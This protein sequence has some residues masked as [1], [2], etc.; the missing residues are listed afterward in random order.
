M[1]P[2]LLHMKRI[3]ITFLSAALL[4]ACGEESKEK[5][6][7]TDKGEPQDI[8][9]Q[10]TLQEESS[11]E[12][13]VRYSQMGEIAM[14]CENDTVVT[15]N[16]ISF[17]EVTPHAD[18]LNERIEAYVIGD[19]DFGEVDASSI[20][21]AVDQFAAD[22]E[23]EAKEF[24]TPCWDFTANADVVAAW[25]NKLTVEYSSYIYS[26]GA[27]GSFWNTFVNLNLNNGQEF[28]LTDVVTDTTALK[29][30][31]EDKFRDQYMDGYDTY[32][33]AGFWIQEGQ[34]PFASTFGLME[35]GIVFVYQ[36]YEIAPYAGG[37][38][39][40]EVKYSE[41]ESFLTDEFKD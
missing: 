1:W 20:K 41:I 34:F 10:D 6:T 30:V 17:D 22:A 39:D 2:F 19:L 4:T 7:S 8:V 9:E 36:L 26:G 29:K 3:T 11:E 15:V 16:Y 14:G 27:H 40:V 31:V 5:E 12:L 25:D 28:D 33:S 23:A 18:M 32:Q 13:E 38:Q 21:E 37:M 24:D 35:D